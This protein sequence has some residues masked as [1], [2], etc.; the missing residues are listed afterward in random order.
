MQI[1]LEERRYKTG[2]EKTQQSQNNNH[3]RR[4][5]PRPKA[6]TAKGAGLASR[7]LTPQSTTRWKRTKSR[8]TRLKLH[9]HIDIMASGSVQWEQGPPAPAKTK[10]HQT[11]GPEEG[12]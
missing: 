1:L 12:G 2:H 3:Q 7:T 4:T 9:G 5:N 11:F 6:K 8:T 10:R